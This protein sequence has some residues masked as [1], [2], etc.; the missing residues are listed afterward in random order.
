MGRVLDTR[1]ASPHGLLAPTAKPGDGW[2]PPVG[3]PDRHVLTCRALTAPRDQVNT[4]S[5]ASLQTEEDESA[6]QTPGR[7]ECPDPERGAH[8][9]AQKGHIAQQR[10]GQQASERKP[11]RPRRTGGNL[12]IWVKPIRGQCCLQMQSRSKVELTPSLRDPGQVGGST[13]RGLAHIS[14]HVKRAGA[15]SR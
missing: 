11:H 4:E 15:S 8:S 10:N 5:I 3:V 1:A 2:R 6:I 13:P 14:G 9:S 12:R 7:D